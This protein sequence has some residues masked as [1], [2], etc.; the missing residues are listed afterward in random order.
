MFYEKPPKNPVASKIY[1]FSAFYKNSP[2]QEAAPTIWA[3]PL[4]AKAAPHS[5]QQ[6]QKLLPEGYA[7]QLWFQRRSGITLPLIINACCR[8]GSLCTKTKKV[9][10]VDESGEF[11]PGL[12][13]ILI[14]GYNLSRKFGFIGGVV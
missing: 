1:N 3:Q 14:F 12:E 9:K 5:P 10:V 6:R 11:A 7:D 8:I 4:N 2:A 13:T